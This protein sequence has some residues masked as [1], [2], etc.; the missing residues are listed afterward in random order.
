MTLTNKDRRGLA[1]TVAASM[2]LAVF[3]LLAIAAVV[4]GTP[5]DALPPWLTGIIIGLAMGLG[6]IGIKGATE[7]GASSEMAQRDSNEMR[8]ARE[9]L[10]NTT[11]RL[12][13]MTDR[14][15]EREVDRSLPPPIRSGEKS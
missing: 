2:L 15:F 3:G 4:K 1:E 7:R 13:L 6:I 9:Q 11:R 14:I 12:E 10:E 5:V 8:A